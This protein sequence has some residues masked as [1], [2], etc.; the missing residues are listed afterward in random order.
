MF[1]SSDSLIKDLHVNYFIARMYKP[2]T[3]YN[4]LFIERL[5]SNVRNTYLVTARA[6]IRSE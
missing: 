3:T 5:T 1:L 4:A 6:W 2:L